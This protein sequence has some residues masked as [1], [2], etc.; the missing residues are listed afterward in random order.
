MN[1]EATWGKKPVVSDIAKLPKAQTSKNEIG[2]ECVNN[3]IYFYAEINRA[4]ILMLNKNIRDLG[5]KL[6][7][8]AAAQDR[9]VSNIY[10]QINSFGGSI[11]AGISA[12]D[13]ILSSK[14]PITT[15]VDGC[16]A[17]A[18]TFLSIVGKHRV[19]RPSAFM[20][21]HQLTSGT[22]GKFRELQDDHVNHTRL[23]KMM[24]KLYSDYTRIPRGKLEEILDHDIW[25]DAKTCLK[26]GLVDE[27]SN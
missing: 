16:C 7:G 3:R 8:E 25:F 24:K 10:L 1:E 21:V 4:E 6:L 27:I 9:S 14:V 12:M 5:S 11:F 23:M 17:S 15:I 13:E 2:I 19:I 22:W 18:A 20:L 26:Y